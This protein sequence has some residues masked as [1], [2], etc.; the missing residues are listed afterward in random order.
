MTCERI[1]YYQAAERTN[2]IRL[3]FNSVFFCALFTAVCSFVYF[4]LPNAELTSLAPVA[5]TSNA[6]VQEKALAEESVAEPALALAEVPAVAVAE[7]P[8][9]ALDTDASFIPELVKANSRA[10]RAVPAKFVRGAGTASLSLHPTAINREDLGLILYRQPQTRAAVEGFYYQ[11][12]GDRETAIAIL[13]AAETYNIPLSLAFSI[14]YAESRFKPYASHVN[15]NGSIDRGLFQL[16]SNA[17]PTLTEEEFFDPKI[18][19]Q[20]GLKHLNYFLRTA[21]NEVT[22]LA[23]YNAGA[24]KVRSNNTPHSTL[25]YVA[26]IN[27]Y[28]SAIDESFAKDVLV[29]FEQGLA[30]RFGEKVEYAQ[31]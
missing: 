16:N 19:A 20:K 18:S 21:G 30:S 11:V 17:F 6:S 28:R 10:N 31:S 8:I 1:D 23:M 14:A 24:G 4:Y 9:L 7:E 5:S 29:F 27:S 25:D 15:K 13:D 22:A 12:T 3:I 26:A 2:V